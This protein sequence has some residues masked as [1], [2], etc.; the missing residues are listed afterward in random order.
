MNDSGEPDAGNFNY[1]LQLTFDNPVDWL[2]KTPNGDEHLKKLE[3]W[4]IIQDNGNPSF[5]IE[6]ENQKFIRYD[7]EPGFNYDWKLWVKT[8]FDYDFNL[9]R[10]IGEVP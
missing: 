4:F 1:F 5:Y 3:V 10:S 2:M 9:Y 7:C 6:D 8:L